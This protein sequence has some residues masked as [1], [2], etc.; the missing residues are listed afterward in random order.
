MK[1][2]RTV[3]LAAGWAALVAVGGAVGVLPAARERARLSAE[4]ESLRVELAKPTDGPEV[5]DRLTEDLNRLREFGRGRMTPIPRES[6]T[7]GL[8]G[9]LSAT[10]TEAG[11]DRRDIT[12]R[13]TK[14]HGDTASLP[15]TV[16]MN[17]RFPSVYR[18]L[19]EIESMPRLVRVE[20][21]RLRA[22][23]T[24][25]GVPDR[26]GHLR[27]ELSIEAFFRPPAQEGGEK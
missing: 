18:V 15:V 20:R 21:V 10:L 27:A 13:S 16:S 2:N 19:A 7:A 1:P 23:E 3:M 5:V 17:G 11:I 22:Q 9:M 14:M 26:D 24:K 25:P 6:D 12:T 4:I 8:M